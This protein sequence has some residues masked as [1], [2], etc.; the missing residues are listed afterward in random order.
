MRPGEVGC[1]QSHRLAWERLL[2]SGGYVVE[3]DAILAADC[4]ER[5]A[6]AITTT[7]NC[8]VI[9]G[10][11]S[12]PRSYQWRYMGEGQPGPPNKPHAS[13]LEELANPCY[14]T[15]MYYVD[16]AAA[17]ALL[18]AS[19]QPRLAAPSDDFLSM[20]AGVHPSSSHKLLRAF[21][22]HP[23]AVSVAK[24]S[25]DTAG[26]APADPVARDRREVSIIEDV[27]AACFPAR[28]DE[29]GDETAALDQVRSG[30]Q[31][32]D[33]VDTQITIV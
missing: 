15:T 23:A 4:F 12:Y 30:L 14:N 21:A 11:Y 32:V 8:H 29:H 3:D 20:A 31:E 1:F 17:S 28:R 10:E 19:S 9:L 6:R 27:L 18:R 13:G 25:S 16:A 24:S 7:P 2:T 5:F 26:D 22:L 33:M